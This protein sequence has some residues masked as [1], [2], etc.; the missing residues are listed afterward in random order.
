MC[1]VVCRSPLTSFQMVNRFVAIRCKLI[2][3]Q[4]I[5]TKTFKQRKRKKKRGKDKWFCTKWFNQRH[6]PFRPFV[7]ERNVFGNCLCEEA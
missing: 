2:T 1:V 3:M 5:V 4:H 7:D 6:V